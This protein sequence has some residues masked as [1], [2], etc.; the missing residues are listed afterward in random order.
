MSSHNPHG[1]RTLPQRFAQE[2]TNGTLLQS[3]RL[4]IV[5]TD[6]ARNSTSLGGEPNY[7]DSNSTDRDFAVRADILES[8]YVAHYHRITVNQTLSMS[9]D[10]YVSP[11]HK[12]F[13]NKQLWCLVFIVLLGIVTGISLGVSFGLT[14]TKISTIS[15]F[16]DPQVF[17]WTNLTN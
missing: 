12:Q 7:T 9:K 11:K 16:S 10:R 1:F 3:F 4:G 17:N 6:F 13:T 14:R 15:W 5:D 8:D 2:K